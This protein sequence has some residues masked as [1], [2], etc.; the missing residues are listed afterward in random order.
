MQLPIEG[1]PSVNVCSG[2]TDGKTGQ[3]ENVGSKMFLL[4]K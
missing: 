1:E 2:M 4:Q 3:M